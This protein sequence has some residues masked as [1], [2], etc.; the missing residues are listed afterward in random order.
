VDRAPD[1]ESGGQEFESLGARQHLAPIFRAKNTAVLRNLQGASSRQFSAYALVHRRVVGVSARQRST[2]VREMPNPY[3]RLKLEIVGSCFAL[4][5]ANGRA[6]RMPKL[7]A[8]TATKWPLRIPHSEWR[9]SN[10]R[11][12]TAAHRTLPF[13]TLVQV[14]HSGCSPSGLMVAAPLHAADTSIVTGRG[15]GGWA[16]PDRARYAGVPL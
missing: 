2:F 4:H 10:C 8:S 11:L 7:L 1:Y 16:E 15:R 9:A 12:M 13:G 3:D 6:P 14:C 5:L